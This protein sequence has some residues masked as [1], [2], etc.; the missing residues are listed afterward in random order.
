MT[1][2]PYPAIERNPDVCYAAV[3]HRAPPS[4]RWSEA[5]SAVETPASPRP[6]TGN[7]SQYQSPRGAI[8]RAWGRPCAG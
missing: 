3:G 1:T 6:N 7:N 4:M 5:A 8:P 2:P